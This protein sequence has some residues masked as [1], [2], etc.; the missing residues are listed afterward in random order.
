MTPRGDYIKE[1]AISNCSFEKVSFTK[2]KDLPFLKHF[3]SF[4]AEK[5]RLAIHNRK[6]ERKKKS[7][8]EIRK[9]KENQFVN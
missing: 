3:F 8:K 6:I 7:H 2:T 9:Q 4:H 5:F 1:T